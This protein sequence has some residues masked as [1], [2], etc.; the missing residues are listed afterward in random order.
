MGNCFDKVISGEHT[1]GKRRKPEIQV[2]INENANKVND[3]IPLTTQTE[4]PRNLIA[5][6]DYSSRNAGD[7]SFKKSD[8][9]ILL[10]TNDHG[11]WQA[12]HSVRGHQG[13]VP[14]NFVA[15]E[16]SLQSEEWYFG[17][18]TRKDSERLLLKEGKKGCFLIRESE[19]SENSYSLSLLNEDEQKEMYVKHYRIHATENDTFFITEDLEFGDLISLINYYHDASH[20]LCCQLI[21]CSPK[22]ETPQTFTLGD[23]IFELTDSNINILEELDGGFNE[24][25]YK[26]SWGDKMD[27]TVKKYKNNKTPSGNL[28]VMRSLHHKSIV[29]YYGM[30]WSG[31]VSYIWEYMDLGN[32]S[33]YLREGNAK[34]LAD[35]IEIA[36]QIASGMAYLESNNFAHRLLRAQSVMV[37][38][39]PAFKVTDYGILES[40]KDSDSE[41]FLW[42]SPE[43]IDSG[44]YDI[45]ADVWSFGILMIEIIT[46][47]EEPYPNTDISR[48]EILEKIKGGYRIPRPEHCPEALYE[49]LLQCWDK[50]SELRPTFEYI[51]IFLESFFQ[52]T[53][54]EAVKGV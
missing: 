7:I 23:S 46:Q 35:Q 53:D 49:L 17:T 10:R 5:L 28:D 15:F 47:G 44:V 36:A 33:R 31:Q 14:S 43:S 50:A 45:K 34:L 19:T 41:A 52:R 39:G 38:D 8:K 30:V 2:V 24:N 3:E 25:V 48:D 18:I 1:S 13:S 40:P 9:L 26:A 12:R 4:E 42:L 21:R 29:K 27:L 6:Y 54:V 20:G 32:L 22:K 16:G 37:K 11:W 51:Q